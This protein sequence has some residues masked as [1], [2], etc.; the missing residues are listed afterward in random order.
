MAALLFRKMVEF[1]G[2]YGRIKKLKLPVKCRRE[3]RNAGRTETQCHTGSRSTSSIF[4]S[5]E[6]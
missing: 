4:I 2:E 3:A 5:G 1:F 6:A